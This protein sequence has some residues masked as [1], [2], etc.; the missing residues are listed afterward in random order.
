LFICSLH[1]EFQDSEPVLSAVLC[2]RRKEPGW[3]YCHRLSWVHRPRRKRAHER[4]PSRKKAT[5]R[6]G[7]QA[8]RGHGLMRLDGTRPRAI[9]GE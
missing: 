3:P 6:C 7:P 1:T 2:S 5:G 4:G 8:C 9:V